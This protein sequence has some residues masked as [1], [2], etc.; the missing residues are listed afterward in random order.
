MMANEMKIFENQTFGEL[1]VLMLDGDPWWVGKEI[2]EKLGY[3]DTWQAL[4]VNVADEDKKVLGPVDFPQ[5][6]SENGIKTVLNIPPR[7]LSIVNE[8]GMFSLVLGSKLPDAK[9]FKRWVTSEVLPSI[10][11]NGGYILGQENA[12]MT[13]E[14]LLARAMIVANNV[15]ADRERRIAEMQQRIEAQD[16]EIMIMTPK[17]EY[18]DKILSCKNTVTAT[19]IAAD[20]GMTAR[21]FNKLLNEQRIQYKVGNQWILYAEYKDQGYVRTE[22]FVYET[23]ALRNCCSQSTKWTQKG[24]IFLY[25]TLKQLNILPICERDGE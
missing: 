1:H 7:G 2:A 12:Q 21:A 20:Y 24:R 4:R 3:K 10:R 5:N 25:N 16:Q 15:I 6:R 8:S 9:K 13:N 18:Y 23:H 17:A 14:E 19:Q 22:S 11:K